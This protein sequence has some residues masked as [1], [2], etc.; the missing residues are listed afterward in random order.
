M[1]QEAIAEQPMTAE[2]AKE[3]ITPF[4]DLFRAEK[5][6]WD[7]GFAVLADDWKSYFN[8]EEYLGKSDTR[9]FLGRLFNLIPDINVDIQQLFVNGEYVAVRSALTGTPN[10]D[11]MGVPYGGKSFNIMTIDILQ[12][13]DGKVIAL[14]HSENWATAI[15]QL[16]DTSGEGPIN[17]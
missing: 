2:E 14:Y 15:E 6:D 16:S 9:E 4:Y 11:F 5:R 1:N 3:I 13:R 12:L 10:D 17:V 8:N 7:K